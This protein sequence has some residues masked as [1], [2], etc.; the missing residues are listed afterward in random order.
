MFHFNI[1]NISPKNYTDSERF[2]LIQLRMPRKHLKPF[3]TMP[4]LLSM[5]LAEIVE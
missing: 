5:R 2:D 4:L 3:L 1:L